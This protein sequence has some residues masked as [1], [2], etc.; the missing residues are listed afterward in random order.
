[1]IPSCSIVVRVLLLSAA[2]GGCV[3]HGERSDLPGEIHLVD[4]EGGLGLDLSGP[5]AYFRAQVSDDGKQ[6]SFL[7]RIEADGLDL[8]IN[9]FFDFRSNKQG[10][11]YVI[12]PQDGGGVINAAT[13]FMREGSLASGSRGDAPRGLL[14]VELSEPLGRASVRFESVRVSGENGARVLSGTASFS[15][16]G[17]VL[18]G[19]GRTRR[20]C[21]ELPE[22]FKNSS[23]GRINLGAGK[24][25][26]YNAAP[27]VCA[28]G[29]S[30]STGVHGEIHTETNN[31]TINHES[32]PAAN[33]SRTGKSIVGEPRWSVGEA[34]EVGVKAV[35]KVTGCDKECTQAQVRAGHEA[36]G[37]QAS[38]QIRPTTAG[39]VTKPRT[40]KPKRR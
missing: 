11:A 9:S 32:V 38:D 19:A 6:C 31:L 22:V 21:P 27:C 13:V 40:I 39:E 26:S 10:D 2:V 17:A 15:Y 36:M 37:I 28:Q 35:E 14:R 25:Y 12:V 7:A 29:N 3:A 1:M 8:R 24:K 30:H 33:I 20:A 18:V 23:G 5:P 4:A 16:L 34:E